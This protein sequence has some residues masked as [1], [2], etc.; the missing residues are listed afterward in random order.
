MISKKLP[1]E[2]NDILDEMVKEADA[3]LSEIAEQH[4]V[5]IT[6][7][8]NEFLKY[9]TDAQGRSGRRGRAA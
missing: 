8:R 3:K 4:G 1:K 9:L 5:S 6:T 7:V 2:V